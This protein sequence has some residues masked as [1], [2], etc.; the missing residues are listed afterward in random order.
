MENKEQITYI[1]NGLLINAPAKINLSLLIAG[2]RPDGFHEIETIMAKINW[3]DEILIERGPEPGINLICKGQYWA[4]QGEENLVYKAAQI[5][6]DNCQLKEPLNITLTKNIPA[7]TGLGSASSDAAATLIGLNKY[8]K[9]EIDNSLN[10]M[11]SDLGS[12]VAFFLDGPLA[13]CTGKGEKIYKIEK[14]FDFTTLLILP[15]ISV[16]TK[17]V[18]ENYRHDMAL[19]EKLK[20]Q[21]NEN[22]TKNRIDLVTKVCA[23]MLELSCFSLNKQLADLK[24]EIEKLN[25]GN[26][27]L[28]GSGSTLYCLFERGD[29]SEVIK[30]QNMIKEKI[31]C[32]CLVASNNR[33]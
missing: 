9:T 13:Y 19:Y 22:I 11:A 18:Y 20:L 17:K 29:E 33:W 16:S 1:G 10:S 5:F 3:Y 12:D 25:I 30:Y 28:S 6:M 2:K 24:K 8:L 14:I 7:G 31:G 23:N 21:I 26:C 32:N 27:C 4:P 15:D